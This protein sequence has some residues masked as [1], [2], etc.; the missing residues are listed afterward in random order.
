MCVAI[1]K[2][3]SIDRPTTHQAAVEKHR[4]EYGALRLSLEDHRGRHTEEVAV[5]MDG[6]HQVDDVLNFHRSFFGELVGCS[7]DFLSGKYQL[8]F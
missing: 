1:L 6:R 2:D 7:R 8:L 3:R 4:A 5:W